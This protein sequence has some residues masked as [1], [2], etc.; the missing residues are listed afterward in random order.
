MQFFDVGHYEN[1]FVFRIEG[2]VFADFAELFEEGGDVD[3][4]LAMCLHEGDFFLE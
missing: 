4:N 1:F 3:G 2:G